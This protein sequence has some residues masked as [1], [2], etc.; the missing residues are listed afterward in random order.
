MAAA[1]F[2]YA[3]RKTGINC[4]VAMSAGGEFV[5]TQS[6]VH[7][8]AGDTVSYWVYAIID[9]RGQ[10]ILDQTWTYGEYPSGTGDGGEYPS[11]T[12][13]TYGE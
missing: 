7:L 13:V 3:G 5:H 9:G 4:L 12:V 8:Q 10:Q 11:E 6:N 2:F 1:S